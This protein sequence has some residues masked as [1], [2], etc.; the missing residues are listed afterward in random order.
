MPKHTRSRRPA[1][2]RSV[3]YDHTT[4]G[5][6]CEANSGSHDMGHQTSY[7]M[8]R[9]TIDNT[10][11][12]CSAWRTSSSGLARYND[13]NRLFA[14]RFPETANELVRRSERKLDSV[15]A[16]EE[17]YM[18]ARD[19][20]AVTTGDDMYDHSTE[21]SGGSSE[22][23]SFMNNALTPFS[24][25]HDQTALSDSLD[26]LLAI[27]LNLPL[28]S[29]FSGEVGASCPRLNET[30]MV[31]VSLGC[32]DM[33][34]LGISSGEWDTSWDADTVSCVIRAEPDPA[35]QQRS[36]LGM[37]GEHSRQGGEAGHEKEDTPTSVSHVR[38]RLTD[39]EGS[40][41]AHVKDQLLQLGGGE[42]AVMVSHA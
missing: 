26:D 23:F 2:A 33:L 6:S 41:Q 25:E 29:P 16:E 17:D 3:A 12:T 9:Y 37:E 13:M 35:G 20:S 19:V 15:L 24:F 4:A 36:A 18:T 1:A 8:T 34:G 7:G 31:D 40:L 39:L 42:T 11:E 28:P 27:N 10:D 5:K 30:D 22:A 38:Q 14:T 21:S 32:G